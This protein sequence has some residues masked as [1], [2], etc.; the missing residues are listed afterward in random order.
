MDISILLIFLFFVLL[1]YYIYVNKNHI[2]GYQTIKDYNSIDYNM[3]KLN[4][5][6]KRKSC[7][8]YFRNCISLLFRVTGLRNGKCKRIY[9][10]ATNDFHMS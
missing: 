9:T 10:M 8:D 4:N 1:I 6:Y 7:D 5:K 2:I 3:I